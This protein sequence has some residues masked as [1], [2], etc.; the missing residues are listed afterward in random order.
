MAEVLLQSKVRVSGTI[1]KN[2]GLPQCLQ[3]I[4][5]SNDQAIFRRKHDILLQIWN[6]G[7]RNV[8]MISTIH[9]ARIMESGSVNRRSHISIQKPESIIDYNKYMKGV[10][11]ADQCICRTT[12]F[13]EKRRS[14][15]NES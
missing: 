4:T 11:R 13:L 8:N 12:L 5:L 9:S 2:I 6:N 14:G 10:D 15:P 1:R 3:K 7:K